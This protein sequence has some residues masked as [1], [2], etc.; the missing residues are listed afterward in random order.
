MGRVVREAAEPER[1]G[2]ER[3]VLDHQ[4]LLEAADLEQVGLDLVDGAHPTVIDVVVQVTA[5]RPRE[6]VQIPAALVSQSRSS[7]K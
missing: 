5:F 4:A 2:R 3:D 7:W 1:L 6:P